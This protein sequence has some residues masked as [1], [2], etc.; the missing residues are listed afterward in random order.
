MPEPLTDFQKNLV[1]LRKACGKTQAEI[2]ELAELEYKHYQ[3]VESGRR[4]DPQLSTLRKIAKAY[5]IELW[6]LLKF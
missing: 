1:K 6:E 2:S 3:D 4:K 5:R